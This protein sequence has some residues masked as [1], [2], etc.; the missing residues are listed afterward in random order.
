MKSPPMRLALVNFLTRF[1]AQRPGPR[2]V[3]AG[4]ERKMGDSR[5][6]GEEPDDT[7]GARK[8]DTHLPASEED[9]GLV[10]KEDN[11]PPQS[12]PGKGGPGTIPPPG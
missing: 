6:T 12:W 5:R 11:G 3:G 9:E 1:L 10:E 4:E 2:F 8:G 7:D